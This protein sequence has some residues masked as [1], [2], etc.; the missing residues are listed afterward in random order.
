M[1]SV[2]LDS[3]YLPFGLISRENIDEAKKIAE[4]IW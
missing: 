1:H 3:T 4:K 2:Q